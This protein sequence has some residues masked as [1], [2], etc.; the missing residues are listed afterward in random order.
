M[1]T[2]EHIG[3]RYGAGP[4]VLHDVSLALEPGEFRFLL[5]ASGSGKTTLLKIICLAELPSHGAL[6]LFGAD[7]GTL[8]R[9]ERAALRRRIGIVLQEFRFIDRLTVGDNVA[10]PLRIADL[11]EAEIGERV[12][13]LLR[14]FELEQKVDALP[15]ELCGSGKQRVAI[16]RAIV[17]RPDL[18][19]ADEP[20]RHA[21]AETADLLVRVFERLNRLGTT[22]LI[23]THD[24]G[25][26]RGFE[27]RCAELEGGSLRSIGAF[28]L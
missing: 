4:E 22:V 9:A 2:L 17:T 21:D 19:I 27:H 23:A 12:A 25:F 20:T 7:A 15:S 26:A 6:R 18:L 13:A 10:L 5:G 24:I 14:W 3:K 16:A 8:D 1:V 28:A 11:P